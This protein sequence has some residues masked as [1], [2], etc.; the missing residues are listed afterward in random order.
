MNLAY[1][2]IYRYMYMYVYACD[3]RWLLFQ[4]L[5]GNA[6]CLEVLFARVELPEHHAP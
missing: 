5:I 3:V 1:Y 4:L 2:Y 6:L